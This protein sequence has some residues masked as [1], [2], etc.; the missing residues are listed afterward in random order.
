MEDIRWH[1]QHE[2]DKGRPAICLH[3]LAMR[4]LTFARKW[5]KPMTLNYHYRLTQV[6]VRTKVTVRTT[7]LLFPITSRSDKMFAVRTTQTARGSLI[8]KLKRT[9]HDLTTEGIFAQITT[10]FQTFS[11]YPCR[12]YYNRN[13]THFVL[14][15]YPALHEIEI[16]IRT[17]SS[18]Q[19]WTKWLFSVI[20]S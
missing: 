4:L 17:W 7:Q 16:L 9:N 13:T 8:F 11:R 20:F 12:K 14:C 2:P 1:G 3:C 19:R 18:Q 6:K 5:L 15:G 10:D